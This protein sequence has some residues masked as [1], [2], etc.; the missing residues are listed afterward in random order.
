[1]VTRSAFRTTA[2]A[3][4]HPKRKRTKDGGWL[5]YEPKG[6]GEVTS[7]LQLFG[8]VTFWLFWGT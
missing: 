6:K 4:V 2:S 7:G 8:G 1:V 5:V 3:S